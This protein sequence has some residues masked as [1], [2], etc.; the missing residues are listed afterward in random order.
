MSEAGNQI[1]NTKHW[2]NWK[3]EDNRNGDS[4]EERCAKN[5]DR[6]NSVAIKT[7]VL[8]LVH[9]TCNW[10]GNLTVEDIS[11]VRMTAALSNIVLRVH[12]INDKLHDNEPAALVIKVHGHYEVALKELKW[13][14]LL[15][16]TPDTHA[17]NLLAEFGNGHIEEC[18]MAESLTA[19]QMRTVETGKAVMQAVA[20][21]HSQYEAIGSG[22][23]DLFKRVYK[24]RGKAE[25]VDLPAFKEAVSY[26]FADKIVRECEV[27]NSKL[28]LSHN[29][30]QMGN[31]LRESNGRITLV[32][33]EYSNIAP[34]GFDLANYF[35]EWMANYA[36]LH[37][38]EIMNPEK[39]PDLETQK[40]LC[41]AYSDGVPS[42]EL[43]AEIKPFIKLS[44]L[45]WIYW[46]INQS[47]CSRI[48]FDYIRYAKNRMLLLMKCMEFPIEK[49]MEL[50]EYR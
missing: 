29:D 16:A 18:I 12:A 8:I 30:L 7:A 37:N 47:I 11:I 21:L 23:N 20:K 50:P 28:V 35:C 19:N 13:L 49:N 17:P 46:A 41:S 6:A 34:R 36:D 24:W 14:R 44:H 38:A 4:R 15:S 45:I 40:I 9:S 10:W 5:Q 31:I 22:E 48:D 25:I 3:E 43:L 33:Y 32:D 39:F 27:V 42:H 1:I 26:E 2:L